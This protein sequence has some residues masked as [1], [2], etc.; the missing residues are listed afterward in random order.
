M[1]IWL[2]I[3]GMALIS[4]LQ[5]WL[6]F[7]LSEEKL[8]AGVR[9][10]LPYVPIAVLSALA[11]VAFLPGE[12][13]FAYTLDAR[14]PAGLAAILVAWLTRSAILTIGVGLAVLVVVGQMVS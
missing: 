4:Y 3:L 2:I 9:R 7:R 1:K 14:L 10:G 12:G 11:G 6:P 13:W 8:P 5:R